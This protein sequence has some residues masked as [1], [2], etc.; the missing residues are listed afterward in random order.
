MKC[1]FFCL[2]FS[3]LFPLRFFY[4][5]RSNGRSSQE[6]HSVNWKHLFNSKA[7]FFIFF[8][9]LSFALFNALR[10]TISV[11]GCYLLPKWIYELFFYPFSEF[12]FISFAPVSCS[13]GCVMLNNF[14]QSSISFLLHIIL[15]IE[16]YY[17]IPWKRYSLRLS[18]SFISALP[19]FG[20][21]IQR[22][23]I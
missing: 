22:Y 19:F 3:L 6:F 8:F 17:L 12:H 10:Q 18:L 5:F 16:S 2:F 4:S 9:L 1:T 23:F 13:V 14:W 20:C 15:L 11:F 21:V 7:V